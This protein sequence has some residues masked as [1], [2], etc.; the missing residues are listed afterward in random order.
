MRGVALG[1]GDGAQSSIVVK[2]G[3]A[4]VWCMRLVRRTVRSPKPNRRLP[5]TDETRSL[6]T[7]TRSFYLARPARSIRN[8][9]PP[10]VKFAPAN[11]AG[12]VANMTASTV[13]QYLA[14]LPAD[15]RAALS[16]VRK[17]INENLPDGYEEGM[18]FGMIGWYVPLSLYPAGYGENPK[19][20]LS[21]V[22]LASQKS[23]MVLHFLCFYGHPTLSTWFTS[24][25]KKS[26]KKLDMGKGCVRF[27]KLEDLALDVVGRTVARVPAEEH[28][29]NY[30]AARALMGKGKKG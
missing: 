2:R 12:I 8:S 7:L 15:R 16:A 6:L 14:A 11:R 5:Q 13:A 19:V 18:Q 21:F 25:Y 1:G 22:A 10:A 24:E 28:M 23:G 17:V 26:G 3:G 29:A 27:K 4:A 30:Q 9:Q 20:P